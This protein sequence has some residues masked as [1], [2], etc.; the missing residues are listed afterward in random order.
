MNKNKNFSSKDNLKIKPKTKSQP[1]AFLDV[2]GYNFNL[3]LDQNGSTHK[4]TFGGVGSIIV[5]GLLGAY[6]TTLFLKLLDHSP[7]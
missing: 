7:Q 1:L 2:V 4:T 5:V 6:F 3:N